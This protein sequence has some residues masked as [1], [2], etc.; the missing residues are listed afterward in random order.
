MEISKKCDRCGGGGYIKREIKLGDVLVP[1]DGSGMPNALHK[2]TFNGTGKGF[3]PVEVLAVSGEMLGVTPASW[4]NKETMLRERFEDDVYP[5][6]T[7]LWANG[8]RY[9]EGFWI[10]AKVSHLTYPD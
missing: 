10:N 5:A 6:I 7:S 3:K 4:N 9:G 8:T 1:H 2:L